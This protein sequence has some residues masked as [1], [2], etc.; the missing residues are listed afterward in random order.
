MNTMDLIYTHPESNGKLYQAGY[1]EIPHDLKKHGIYHLP[2]E[3][4]HPTS[5]V[6]VFW[7]KMIRKNRNP[8]ALCNPTF[9]KMLKFYV[10]VS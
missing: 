7:R 5:W 4:P 8:S 6:G 3:D 9:E 1:Q 10:K 2:P